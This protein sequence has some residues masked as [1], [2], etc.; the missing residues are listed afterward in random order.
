MTNRTLKTSDIMTTEDSAMRN[1]TEPRKQVR[2]LQVISY[3]RTSRILAD[4]RPHAE[5]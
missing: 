3:L 5:N 1:D 4:D 2:S